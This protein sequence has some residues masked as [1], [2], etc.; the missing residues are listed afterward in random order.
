ML[1]VQNIFKD[2]KNLT[3]KLIEVG[4]SSQQ[5]FPTLNNLKYC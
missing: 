4:L 1:N 2:V 5:N 3:A